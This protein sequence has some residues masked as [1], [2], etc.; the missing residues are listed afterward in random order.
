MGWFGDSR[1]VLNYLSVVGADKDSAGNFLIGGEPV[2]SGLDPNGIV[3]PS[4]SF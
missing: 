3:F 2:I 1:A 4:G